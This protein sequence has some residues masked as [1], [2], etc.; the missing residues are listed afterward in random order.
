MFNNAGAVKRW[1]YKCTHNHS[2]H[3]L[4]RLKNRSTSNI[5]FAA[6]RDNAREEWLFQAIKSSHKEVRYGSGDNMKAK[7]L[8]MAILRVRQLLKIWANCPE[9]PS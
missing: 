4:K 1:L 5:D 2:L 7:D 9:T 6:T 8:Y 3:Y